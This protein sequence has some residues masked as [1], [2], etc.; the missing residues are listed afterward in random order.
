MAGRKGRECPFVLNE[1][2]HF[3]VNEVTTD[4]SQYLFA[5]MMLAMIKLP[6]INPR[7][8]FN[9]SIRSQ[10]QKRAI[11]T[12]NQDFFFDLQLQQGTVNEE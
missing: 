7:S 10:E 6:E 3:Q 4:V 11:R 1:C 5:I 12:T 9:L 8:D 2:Q